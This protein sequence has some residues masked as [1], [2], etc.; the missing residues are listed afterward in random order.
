[1]FLRKAV[2][3][4]A[5]L[6]FTL[7]SGLAFAGSKAATIIGGSTVAASDPD[8]ASTVAIVIQLQGGQAICTGSLLA[9]DILVTAAHCVTDESG[10]TVSAKQLRLV[11]ATDVRSTSRKLVNATGVKRH[12]N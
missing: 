11:F 9:A 1:M 2:P 7:T 8:A 12:P 3:L 6:T 10:K 5:V 4:F